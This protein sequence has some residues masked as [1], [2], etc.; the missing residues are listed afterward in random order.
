[1][2]QEQQAIHFSEVFKLK[3]L[4]GVAYNHFDEVCDRLFA[5]LALHKVV[6]DHAK[7]HAD[8]SAFVGFKNKG[9]FQKLA[10]GIVV[11]KLQ[12]CFFKLF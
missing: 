5:G 9:R 4:F 7:E 3:M 6:Q 11:E 8:E 1:M 10:E 2:T 12:S